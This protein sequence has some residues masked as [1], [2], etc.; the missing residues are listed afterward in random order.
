MIFDC[1]IP[2]GPND[3]SIIVLCINKARENIINL[4]NIYVI[5][6]RDDFTYPGV[7]C[8]SEKSFPFSKQDI[9]KYVHKGRCGW[10]F[11]QFLKLYAH[12]VIPDLSEYFLVLDSDTIFLNRTSFF[13]E[14]NKPLYNISNE[15]HPP[16]FDTM[17][18]II[19]INKKYY[20]SGISNHMIFKKEYLD[21]LL[22]LIETKTGSVFWEG[23]LKS[24]D[25]DDIKVSGFSEYETYFSFID[26]YHRDNVKIRKLLWS[27]TKMYS[28]T[29]EDLFQYISIHWYS[30]IDSK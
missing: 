14:T 27:C 13:D 8:I 4:R 16:Y 9:E 29:F 22:W 21:E 18:K 30:R 2:L 1:V 3:E 15:Y 5:S 19:G 20:F 17:Q 23:I 10:Y 25:P 11:Q 6:Y 26:H 7:T 24:I 28:E 12:R